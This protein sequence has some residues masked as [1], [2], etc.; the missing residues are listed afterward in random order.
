MAGN[1]KIVHGKLLRAGIRV[2]DALNQTDLGTQGGNAS[3]QIHL[4]EQGV[5]MCNDIIALSLLSWLFEVWERNVRGFTTVS[6][7]LG[8]CHSQGS[9]WKLVMMS[10][11][12][13]WARAGKSSCV[14]WV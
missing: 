12:K 11:L 4:E 2:M 1:K 3:S 7:E 5:V 10:A 9:V 13:S 8:S 14:I 6:Q